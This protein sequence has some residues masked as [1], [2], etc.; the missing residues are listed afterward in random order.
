MKVKTRLYL[1]RTN[2]RMKTT[3]WLLEHSRNTNRV[4]DTTLK[5][6]LPGWKF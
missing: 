5:P 6:Q 2:E 1:Q 4:R 3:E